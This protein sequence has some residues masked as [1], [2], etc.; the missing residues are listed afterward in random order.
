MPNQECE[1]G[2]PKKWLSYANSD[3]QLAR[4]ANSPDIMREMLCFH[5]QQAA[6][7]AIKAVLIKEN[8]DFPRTHNLRILLD[9]IPPEINLPTAMEDAAILTDYAVSARYPGDLED[10][11]EEEYEEALILSQLVLDWAKRIIR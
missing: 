9:K 7:K 3:L 6:E 5:A 8:I 10:V 1:P 4:I 2:S 11:T